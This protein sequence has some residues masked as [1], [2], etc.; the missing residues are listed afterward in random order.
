MGVISLEEQ[1]AKRGSSPVRIT[2]TLGDKVHPWGSNFA[3][4]G[5]IKI[6]SVIKLTL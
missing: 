1:V 6:D 2:S 3:P 4:R 5:E